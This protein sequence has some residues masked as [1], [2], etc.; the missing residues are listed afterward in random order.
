MKGKSLKGCIYSF[1][2]TLGSD[3]GLE[4]DGVEGLQ[5][6]PLKHRPFS[7]SKCFF[8]DISEDFMLITVE[9]VH[10]FSCAPSP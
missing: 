5:T 1:T 10:T 4:T 6:V 7:L 3:N 9:K 2:E 8:G